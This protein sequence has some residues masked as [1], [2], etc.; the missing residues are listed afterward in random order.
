MS[1]KR[2]YLEITDTREKEYSCHRGE[3]EKQHPSDSGGLGLI[4]RK[5]HC[6]VGLA[7]Q[8]YMYTETI[9]Y[10]SAPGEY[11]LTH[12]PRS[13]SVF[14]TLQYDMGL[15]SLLA[16]TAILFIML[17]KFKALMTALVGR[18]MVFSDGSSF[19]TLHIG[20][21]VEWKSKATRFEKQ[22]AVPHIHMLFVGKVNGNHDTA[23]T[24]DNVT[25][26]LAN[27]WEHCRGTVYRSCIKTFRTTSGFQ[28]AKFHA[29][30]NAYKYMTKESSAVPNRNYGI[31]RGLEIDI[32]GIFLFATCDEISRNL[33][34]FSPVAVPVSA[35]I[36]HIL[37][38]YN[39]YRYIY[40]YSPLGNIC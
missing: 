28:E 4:S 26:Q 19:Y 36:S 23:T 2:N 1:L 35:N 21:V 38:N 33:P 29:I 15:A 6:D 39:T 18:D 9:N 20:I 12:F 3:G 27:M 14:C 22:E 32:S 10:L 37:L 31:A 8:G 7:D 16:S 11:A 13:L 5:H 17:N 40:N 25:F 34:A 24:T 30:K